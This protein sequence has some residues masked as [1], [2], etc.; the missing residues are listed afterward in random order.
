MRD[1]LVSVEV[2]NQIVAMLKCLPTRDF[3]YNFLADFL[4]IIN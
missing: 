1:E 3:E 2:M 4:M